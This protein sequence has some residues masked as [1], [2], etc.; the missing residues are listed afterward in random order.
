MRHVRL[1]L[2]FVVVMACEDFDRLR[3]CARLADGGRVSD[4]CGELGGGTA[5]GGSA[6]GLG[7]G[8]AGG[9]AGAG[10]ASGGAAGGD[11]GGTAGGVSGGGMSGGLAGGMGG[12]AGGTSGGVAGGTSGGVAGGTSGG[13][14]G[15]TSGGVAGG[16]A[17]GGTSSGGPLPPWDG[18]I[19]SDSLAVTWRVSAPIPPGEEGRPGFL[20][21]I[22]STTAAHLARRTQVATS[23]PLTTLNLL[24]FTLGN[25]RPGIP[26]PLLDVVSA[27][28]SRGRLSVVEWDRAEPRQTD[29]GDRRALYFDS[30]NLLL[31]R[32]TD[33]GA[34]VAAAHVGFAS[35]TSDFEL[36]NT[37]PPQ[38]RHPTEGNVALPC[39]ISEVGQAVIPELTPG[40]DGLF[41][42][43]L[44][45]GGI[46]PQLLT[47]NQLVSRG[48]TF[49]GVTF[50]AAA[51]GRQGTAPVVGVLRPS[52]PS[53]ELTL[54][55]LS[56]PT[57]G[58][59]QSRQVN[60]DRFLILRAL[61]VDDFDQPIALLQGS[62]TVSLVDVNTGADAGVLSTSNLVLL[63]FD[64]QLNPRVLYG[65]PFPRFLS[66]RS[67]LATGGRWILE[68]A[69]LSYVDAGVECPANR[70]SFAMNLLL[71]DG[72]RP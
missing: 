70:S 1:L 3:D 11:A 4:A 32:A 30:T 72:G 55:R 31:Q 71:A 47:P 18:G 2:P 42:L 26:T 58:V 61:A 14:A 21:R 66:S 23:R 62:T 44:C 10:G 28:S 9:S 16:G 68:A 15:G 7:G 67:V 37:N 52:G 57:L 22:D 19:R 6:G 33:A 65:V 12:G 49:P 56:L 50:S 5:A 34:V 27:H 41:A 29:G 69:C 8:T 38:R 39:P 36:H 13:V 35:N 63:Q 64:A 40:A 45:D 17:G 46:E 53:S 59:V 20:V 48:P 24:D 51:V 60:L 54:T 25:Y 43:G